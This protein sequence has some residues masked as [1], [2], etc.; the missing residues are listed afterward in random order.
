MGAASTLR[1]NGSMGLRKTVGRWALVAVA[2]PVTAKAADRLGRRL[3]TSRGPNVWSKGLRG[4]A[5][6]LNRVQGRKKRA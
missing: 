5:A 6:R 4:G 3:E 2:V 1:V